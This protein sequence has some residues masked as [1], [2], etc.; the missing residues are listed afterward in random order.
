MNLTDILENTDIQLA[1][2]SEQIRFCYKTMY[3]LRPHLTSE[4]AFVSQVQRQIQKDI[5]WHISKM[6]NR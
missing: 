3:Q 4:Q 5:V 2:D 1:T 6:A